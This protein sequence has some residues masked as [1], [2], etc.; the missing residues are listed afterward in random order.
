MVRNRKDEKTN[1]CANLELV[2][3]KEL[4]QDFRV[5]TRTIHRWA[6]NGIIPRP[7]R[8]TPRLTRFDKAECHARMREYLAE[9][10]Q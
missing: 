4:A 8:V 10:N 7:V 9:M 3:A 2:T 6:A 1:T 5:S